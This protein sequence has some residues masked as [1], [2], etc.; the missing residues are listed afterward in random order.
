MISASDGRVRPRSRRLIGCALGAGLL[1]KTNSIPVGNVEQIA[2]QIADPPNH[3]HALG[4][5]DPQLRQSYEDNFAAFSGIADELRQI[6]ALIVAHDFFRLIEGVH[7]P[8]VH[9]AVEHLLLPHLRPVLRQWYRRSGS[10]M[11][12][13]ALELRDYL[14]QLAGE[15]LEG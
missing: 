7:S 11:D 8:R 14:S 4:F 15:R 6:Y 3:V 13:A 9:E 2:M 12:R 1:V 5:R 10:H